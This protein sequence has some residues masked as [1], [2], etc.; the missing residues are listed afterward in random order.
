MLNFT[1]FVIVFFKDTFIGILLN[2]VTRFIS[3][4]TY[5]VSKS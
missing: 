2:K 4:N 1:N 3:D 5:L